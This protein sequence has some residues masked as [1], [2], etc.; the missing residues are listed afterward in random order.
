MELGGRSTATRER[1][2][3][4]SRLW[5]GNARGALACKPV[6]LFPLLGGTL[7]RV[8]VLAPAAAGVL[9]LVAGGASADTFSTFKSLRLDAPVEQASVLAAADTA[10]G[11]TVADATKAKPPMAGNFK[12]T[13]YAARTRTV[14][15]VAQGLIVGSGATIVGDNSIPF[16]MCMFSGSLTPGAVASAKGWVGM[17]PTATMTFPTAG[18]NATMNLFMFK[19][20]PGGR[21]PLD[22]TALSGATPRGPY[23]MIMIMESQGGQGMLARMDVKP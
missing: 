10:G 1:P 22:A 8:M 21:A 9:C 5:D 12:L 6:V 11:W 15:G 19:D 18:V 20:V 17:P 23:S 4:G 14:D 2:R 3:A 7:M 16:E 13:N